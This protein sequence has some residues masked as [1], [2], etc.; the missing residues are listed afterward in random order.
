MAIETNNAVRSIDAYVNSLDLAAM[1]FN[2]MEITENGRPAYYPCDL[3][4][5]NIYGYLNRT[6]SSRELE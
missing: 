4:K 1:G 5:L 3:L 6:R 2:N